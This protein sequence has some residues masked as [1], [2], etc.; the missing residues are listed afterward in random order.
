MSESDRTGAAPRTRT[1]VVTFLGSVVRPMGDWM[2]IGGAVDLLGEVGLDPTSVRTAVFRLKKRGWLGS[3]TRGGVRGY[4]LTRQ[5]LSS[6]AAGDEV[7]WHARRPA[8]LDEGWCVV[9]FSVPEAERAK[10][11]QLRSHL[12]ALGFGNVGTAMWIAP[13]RMRAAAEQAIAELE[14][15]SYS[16]VFVGPHVGGQ[17]LRTLVARSWDLDGIAD[18]YRAFLAH[19]GD[20]GT[21]TPFASYVSLVDHWRKLPFRDPG[22]PPELLP[23]DWPAGDALAL[24]EGLVA[25]L[26][27]PALAHAGQRWTPASAAG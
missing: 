4:A 13:A 9:N 10:R 23:A 14:L 25:L 21:A 27:P 20:T 18:G 24:F 26:E 11:H 15:T 8:P 19:F 3:Q 22:L 17:D 16:A 12:A 6:L 2:P 5:A 7:I 1:V